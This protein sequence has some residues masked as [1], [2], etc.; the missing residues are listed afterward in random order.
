MK[1]FDLHC[2][3]ADEIYYSKTVL[4]DGKC[5]VSLKKAEIFDKYIQLFALF[6]YPGLNDDD[7]FGKICEIR[8]NFMAECE[9]NNVTMITSSSELESFN[10]SDKKIGGILMIED[11]RI[12]G[13]KIERVQEL[14][15]LG[16]RVMTLLWGGDT[17]IG[18]SH[19]SENGL[20]DFGK[21]AV[22][23]MLRVGI[24]PDISHASFKSADDILDICE[25]YGKAPIATHMNSYS[26]C[27]HTRNLTDERFLRLIKLGGIAGVSLCPYHLVN[28]YEQTH[29]AA[30]DT[31]VPHFKKY[32]ELSP[33]HVCFG[34]DMD[35]TNLPDGIHGL[36]GI[37]DAIKLLSDSGFSE[38]Q[39]DKI[40]F[41]TAY[42]YMKKNLPNK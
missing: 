13:N 9:K 23:E 27:Q 8:E 17:S 36:D 39:L 35:G 25:K 32:E 28:G 7:G 24:I 40:S 20:T 15:D 2:D 11:S 33:S 4:Y 3:T 18:G 29:E 37:P 26:V 42:E 12:L 22:E 34:C 30:L 38:E 21:A 41:D 10:A 1:Y 19:D 16:I 14:Y 31:I 6:P 5:Q